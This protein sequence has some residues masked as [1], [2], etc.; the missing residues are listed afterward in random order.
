[1]G[2]I[3]ADKENARESWKHGGS[4]IEEPYK[5]RALQFCLNVGFMGC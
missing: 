1:M 4:T 3:D 5:A 2:C